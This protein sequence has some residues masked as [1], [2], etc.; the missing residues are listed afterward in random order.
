MGHRFQSNVSFRTDPSVGRRYRR[1]YHGRVAAQ[2][3][4]SSLQV[5]F[6]VLPPW[7]EQAIFAQLAQHL[8]DR[9]EPAIERARAC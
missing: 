7:P 3:T 8:G 4:M 9:P 5:L 6:R 2:V 1:P